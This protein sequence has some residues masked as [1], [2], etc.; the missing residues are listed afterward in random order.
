MV[1]TMTDRGSVKTPRWKIAAEN[2]GVA[3]TDALTVFFLVWALA[4]LGITL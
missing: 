3:V 1:E 4:V 2:A